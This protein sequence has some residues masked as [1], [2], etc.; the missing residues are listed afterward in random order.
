MGS[1]MMRGGSRVRLSYRY[2]RNGAEFTEVLDRPA[3]ER[4]AGVLLGRIDSVKRAKDYPA[5]PSGLCGWCGYRE[6]CGDSGYS[7]SP[8]AA[9]QGRG[10]VCPCCGGKLVARRGRY[11]AFLG[12][13]NYPDCRY[14]RNAD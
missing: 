7:G 14:T 4:T 11:G 6:L 1:L 9:D 10:S 8:N 13:G 5:R 3:A 12:C 2:L